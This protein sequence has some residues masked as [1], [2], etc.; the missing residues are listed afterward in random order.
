MYVIYDGQIRSTGDA[1]FSPYLPTV[2]S[3]GHGNST[4]CHRTHIHISLSW[5]GALGRTS[6]WTRQ[7]AKV[8][9]GPCV[10][11][12]HLFAPRYSHPQLTPCPPAPLRPLPRISTGA[13]GPVVSLLQR[14]LQVRVDGI[15]GPVTAGAVR[16]WKIAHRMG[17]PNAV[18][19]AQVWDALNTAG[20]LK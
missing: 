3:N 4:T 15:F 5:A 1:A 10:A 8:D 16:Q 2:C 6:Y 12:G 9:Y 18:V 7:V 19:D 11:P 14:A 17:L 20:L 13:T